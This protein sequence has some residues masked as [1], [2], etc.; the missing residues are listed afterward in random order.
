MSLV[1]RVTPRRTFVLLGVGT[2][3]FTLLQS[4]LNP[5]LPT[6]Q[7]DLHTS[8]SAVTWVIIAWILSAAIATPLLGRV[9]DMIGKKRTFVAVLLAVVVGSVIAAI[10]PNVTVLIIARV[11]QGLGGAVMPLAFGIIRDE[12]PTNRV[13]SA[14]GMMSAVIAVGGGA[15]VVLAGP[16]VAALDW[17]WLFWIPAIAS[18][19]TATL[20]LF[21]VPESPARP[22]GRINWL[23]AGLLAGWLVAL[24]LPL[25]EGSQWGWGSPATII[26]LV[27]AALLIVVWIWYEART[28]NPVID[29]QMMRIP[30]V[31]TVNLVGLL[32]G[33]GMFST[34]TF[35]PQFSQTPTSAGYGFGAS[36]SVAGLL[37]LPVLVTMAIS[38]FLSAPISRV[39]SFKAQLAYSAALAGVSTAMLAFFHTTEWE[40]AVAGGIFGLGLG[41]GYAS[42]ASLMVQSVPASQTGVATG[43][44]ANIRNIGGAI[45]TALVSSIVTGSAT[46]NGIP[47][48]SGYTQA[49]IALTAVALI[50]V[51]VSALIPGARRRRQEV[52]TATLELVDA[53]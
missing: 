47:R 19:V 40:V 26:L 13:S 53:A 11:I 14:I 8:Q 10:A 16:I 28:G 36:I 32:F 22:G 20:A 38:G 44:N 42:M 18:T 7:H 12:F 29:M 48:E 34:Y 15:G 52:A 2:A 4:L 33:A 27:V 23:A 43:M 37:M 17:R 49:F 50:A 51:A 25:S 41:F 35:L 21:F 3:S 9:G 1:N 30:A 46:A 24:L 31:W 39:V 45:G 5:A 6:I